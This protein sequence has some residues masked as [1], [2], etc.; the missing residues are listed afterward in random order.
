ME[1]YTKVET[2]VDDAEILSEFLKEGEGSEANVNAKYEE[3]LA[4]VD[5]LE[6]RSTLN[7]PEDELSAIL[8]I[9]SGAGGT[10]ANDWTQ[11]IFRMY[12]MW[13][14]KKGFKVSILS[15]TDGD[16]AGIKSV[17]IEI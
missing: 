3:A 14:D 2:I 12:K 7:K 1:N 5:D 8:E 4:A 9:N 11:M 13:A 16:V 17:S 15:Q 6:F 10:E